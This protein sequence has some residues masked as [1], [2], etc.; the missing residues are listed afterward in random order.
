MLCHGRSSSG[1]ETNTRLRYS[2]NEH[3]GYSSTRV[4]A[5]RSGLV[6]MVMPRSGQTSSAAR[7]DS[8]GFGLERLGSAPHVPLRQPVGCEERTFR[9]PLGRRGAWSTLEERLC[10]KVATRAG[11][12]RRVSPL[13]REC[14]VCLV[15]QLSPLPGRPPSSTRRRELQDTFERFSAKAWSSSARNG[16]SVWPL[17]RAR[18]GACPG[19]RVVRH[20]GMPAGSG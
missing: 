7:G 18:D 20:E 1:C 15:R 13:E 5:L 8:I 14:A 6:K 3:D 19:G 16:P 11:G 4:T 17:L 12:A 2:A 9:G 10:R